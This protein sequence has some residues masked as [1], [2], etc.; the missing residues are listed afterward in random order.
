MDQCE[1]TRGVSQ[2]FSTLLILFRSLYLYIHLH[3]YL[4]LFPTQR[5]EKVYLRQ[6]RRIRM[7][8]HI[9]RKEKDGDWYRPLG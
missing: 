6:R 1:E 8:G 9:Q 4:Y 2:V 5:E 3:L 7:E